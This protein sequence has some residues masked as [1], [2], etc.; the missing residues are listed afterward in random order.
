MTAVAR[1]VRLG[2]LPGAALGWMRTIS[3][4]SSLPG[5]MVT[6]S[7]AR[8]WAPGGRMSWTLSGSLLSNRRAALTTTSVMAP[9][10]AL[11]LGGTVKLATD[12]GR[13][14]STTGVD[15]MTTLMFGF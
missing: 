5:G 13:M 8:P 9:S 3:L 14:V 11:M 10:L 4:A 6:S 2:R 1:M 7:A 15:G 12:L